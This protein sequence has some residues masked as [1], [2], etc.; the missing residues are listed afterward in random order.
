MQKDPCGETVE[1]VSENRNTIL[2]LNGKKLSGS[3]CL[4]FPSKPD[5]FT[6]DLTRK[7]TLIGGSH[8]LNLENDPLRVVQGKPQV[9]FFQETTSGNCWKG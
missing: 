9:V 2:H 5:S 6:S 4:S 7:E 8:Q 1:A 3:A